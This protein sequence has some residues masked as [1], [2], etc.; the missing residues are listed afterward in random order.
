[1]A[2]FLDVQLP[3]KESHIERTANEPRETSLYRVIIADIEQVNDAIRVFRLDIPNHG[4][5]KFLPGQWLDVYLPTLLKPGGFTITSTPSAAIAPSET[6]GSQSKAAGYI[7][8]AIQKSP[9]N[10][11]AAWLWQPPSQI[12]QASIHVR[13]G[14]SF[15][16][17][18]PPETG[19]DS[20]TLRRVVFIAGGVG[21]NPLMSM[22]SV[23]AEAPPRPPSRDLE[24][25]FL[26]SMRDPG[27]PRDVKHML[28]LER[29]ARVF[30]PGGLKGGLRL[31]LT[32]GGGGVL[33]ETVIVGLDVPFE[34]RRI[35]IDDVALAAGDHKKDA[36]VYVCGPPAMTDGFVE[37]LTSK[38]GLAMD[39]ERVLFEKWW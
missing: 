22:L 7:E 6:A 28:F 18:P 12:A 14:G 25:Y 23:L 29:I 34:P 11:P 10:P 2:S 4:T 15:V 1:M 32:G 39:T 27:P 8:L 21:V 24:V 26:Y 38:D 13:V 17:P 33:R 37:E 20:S 5:I 36:A 3:V 31:F 16:F 30:R 9:S 19:I 35:D